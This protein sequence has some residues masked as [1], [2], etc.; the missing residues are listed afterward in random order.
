MD[1]N[2]F[3]TTLDRMVYLFI[4][5]A[6]GYALM[7][8]K[9]LPDNTNTVL[10]KLENLLFL[11]ALMLSTFMGSF[12]TKM[13]AVSGKL[14][15]LS[16]LLE[17]LVIPLAILGA[18]LCFKGDYLRKIATYGLSFSNFG[19]M[20]NAVMQ[21]LFPEIFLEYSVFTLPLWIIIM[22]WGV[23][24]L[25]ISDSSDKKLTLKTRLKP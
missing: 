24:Y 20:G 12:T 17:M 4:F 13:L 10:S 3:S 15:L 16:F 2:L 23:P 6:L 5:I 19:F 8:M 25:L 1:L 21:A 11:P 22:L 7:K 18:R 14:L 9:L